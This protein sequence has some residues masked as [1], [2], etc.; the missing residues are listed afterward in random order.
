[1]P[2]NKGTKQHIILRLLRS[3]QAI[4]HWHKDGPPKNHKWIQLKIQQCKS[5]LLHICT[6]KFLPNFAIQRGYDTK[7]TLSD[8]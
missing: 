7:L 1:M 6:Y 3:T 2:L 8:V 5:L 4:G